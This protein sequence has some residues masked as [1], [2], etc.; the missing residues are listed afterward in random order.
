MNSKHHHSPNDNMKKKKAIVDDDESLQTFS[1]TRLVEMME[2]HEREQQQATKQ[3]NNVQI[4]TFESNSRRRSMNSE[5]T[6]ASVSVV[7]VSPIRKDMDH[8]YRVPHIYSSPVTSSSLCT[9]NEVSKFSQVHS[10]FT[11]MA[12][13]TMHSTKNMSTSR[14]K[15]VV[16]AV[17]SLSLMDTSQESIA[18]AP[19]GPFFHQ[20][21][22]LQ[23]CE[24]ATTRNAGAT[25]HALLHPSRRFDSGDD[26]SFILHP[27]LHPPLLQIDHWS[28]PPFPSSDI[29]NAT[30]GR[31]RSD[32]TERARCRQTSNLTA[33]NAS[34][35]SGVGKDGS[36]MSIDSSL[37]FRHSGAESSNTST[38]SPS[39]PPVLIGTMQGNYTNTAL[40]SRQ[41]RPVSSNGTHLQ[42]RRHRRQYSSSS[43]TQ[44]IAIGGIPP[45]GSR[46][47][48]FSF[49]SSSFRSSSQLSLATSRGSTAAELEWFCNNG[50]MNRQHS[51]L[52]MSVCSSKSRTTTPPDLLRNTT[53]ASVR[54]ETQTT[55]RERSRSSRNNANEG[56]ERGRPINPIL[57]QMKEYYC[58]SYR[59]M[60][61]SGSV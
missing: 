9:D 28:P 48:L 21:T 12:T 22:A 23:E 57:S 3:L 50:T 18:L 30:S 40:P 35:S 32:D 1:R 15:K 61:T 19:I 46:R 8:Q 24:G 7:R 45:M 27:P 55:M 60:A 44:D 34:D 33:S 43:L 47:S 39:S 36:H 42:R 14:Q 41:H 4:H 26:H 6:A 29:P 5:S 53:N 10:A 2:Q 13:R 31:T 16:N 54:E 58:D 11:T 17:A 49:G 37:S 56:N 59:S 38:N 52:S 25:S 51:S 20:E